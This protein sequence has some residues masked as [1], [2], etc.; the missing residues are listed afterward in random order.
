MALN[1]LLALTHRAK[2][3]IPQ[4]SMS[5]GSKRP[6][7]IADPASF[8]LDPLNLTPSM[9]GNHM[10]AGRRV[11]DSTYTEKPDM[12]VF[13]NQP[14]TEDLEVLGIPSVHLLHTS[15]PPFA[16][17]FIRLS[18]LD[19]QGVS[20]NITELYTA[21]DL[22]RDAFDPLNLD[23]QYCT[24]RFRAG[25][26][27]RVIVVGGSFPMYARSLGTGEDRVRSD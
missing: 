5:I 26:R 17:L 21:L 16:D 9:G 8:V 22:T 7:P 20:H 10:S 2:D 27:V 24:H 11:D 3:H 12:L 25:T 4:E 6:T 1:A 18:E 14:L 19:T 13:T 23:L 15:D